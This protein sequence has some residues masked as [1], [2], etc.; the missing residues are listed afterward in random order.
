VALAKGTAQEQ[1]FI[2][3]GFH[4]P[5]EIVIDGAYW[6]KEWKILPIAGGWMEQDPVLMDDILRYIAW[7]NG[8]KP[9]TQEQTETQSDGMVNLNW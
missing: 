6:L 9:I 4:Y 1:R 2:D 5:V 3:I 8:I 7:E